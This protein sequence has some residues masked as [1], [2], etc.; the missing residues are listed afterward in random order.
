M[1]TPKCFVLCKA[2]VLMIE[3]RVYILFSILT[4]YYFKVN[5]VRQFH[6]IRVQVM[7]RIILKSSATYSGSIVTATYLD[8]YIISQINYNVYVKQQKQDSCH[9]RSTNIEMRSGGQRRNSIRLRS[10]NTE[11][12]IVNGE[13]H[14]LGS[15]NRTN[16]VIGRRRRGGNVAAVGRASFGGAPAKNHG[17][18]R[19]RREASRAQSTENWTLVNVTK[20]K[21]IIRPCAYS[22]VQHYLE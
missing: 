3:D 8:V 7:Y 20:G 17:Y 22:V 18:K 13:Q 19:A 5:N 10:L 21:S 1:I 6:Y 9:T 16:D 12:I 11:L 2:R 4:S 14:E 15:D